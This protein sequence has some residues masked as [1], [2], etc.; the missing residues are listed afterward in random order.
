MDDIV[1]YANSLEE[2]NRKLKVLLARLQNSGLT[3][4]PQKCRFL[5]KEIIYLGHVISSAGVKPDP[6]KVLAVMQFP[7]PKSRK[8]VKQFLGLVGYYR[9]FIPNMAKIAKPL[10]SLLKKDTPFR[11]TSEIQRSFEQLRDIIC[12]EPLLQYPDFTKPFLVTT[13]SSDYAVGAVLS[14]GEVGSDLPISYASRTL[15]GAETNYSA[16]EKELLAVL[17]GVEHFRPYLYG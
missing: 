6:G 16:I 1:V 2:H 5:R 15:N 14:Q 11:W 17:F 3:L 9:K 12:S 10:T 13:D 4:Q 7:I 8:S